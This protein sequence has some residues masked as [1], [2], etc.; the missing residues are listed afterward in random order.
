MIGNLS[1]ERFAGNLTF[2]RGGLS[3]ISCTLAPW[4]GAWMA[5]MD[6]GES[7]TVFDGVTFHHLSLSRLQSFYLPGRKGVGKV[8]FTRSFISETWHDISSSPRFVDTHRER[9]ATSVPPLDFVPP[10]WAFPL[11]ENG[12]KISALKCS[13]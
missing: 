12:F 5:R 8:T 11:E 1:P 13:V 3:D 4:P 7:G 10:P 6:D 2:T 9:V